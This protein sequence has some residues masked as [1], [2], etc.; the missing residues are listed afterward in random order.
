[1]PAAHPN[2]GNDSARVQLRNLLTTYLHAQDPPCP[3]G[4]QRWTAPALADA[5]ITPR[6]LVGDPVTLMVSP[7]PSHPLHPT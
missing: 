5:K 7:S 6:L 1:M 2:I 3:S 4:Y